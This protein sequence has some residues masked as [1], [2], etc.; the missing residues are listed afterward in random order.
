[1]GVHL[2]RE[3]DRLKRQVLS[4]CAQVEEN[5]QLAVRALLERDTD[6]AAEVKR[7]DESIDNTEVDVE[8]ECLKILALHQPVANDLRYV[9]ASL[10]IDNELERIGDLAVNIANKASLLALAPPLEVPFDIAGMTEKTQ[11]MLRRS[12]D[13][14]IHLNAQ[15]ADQVCKDDD[16][17]DSLKKEARIK[18]C[19][20]MQEKPDRIRDY[21]ALVGISCNLERISDHATNIAEDVIYMIEARI[22]RHAET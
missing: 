7:R 12:I 8:E 22:V 11:A 19:K 5:V 14:F 16:E 9:I 15:M 1:M 6:L 18:C 4:L 13:A 17:V 21:M 3:I 2:Q 20:L 10:K